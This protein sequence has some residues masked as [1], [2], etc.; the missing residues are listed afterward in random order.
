M[1]SPV[2]V[3]YAEPIK[4]LCGNDAYFDHGSGIGYRCEACMAMVG[5]IGMPRSCKALY[6]QEE[7]IKKLKGVDRENS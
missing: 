2:Q 7:V 3:D 1:R 4:L 6:E 5:S